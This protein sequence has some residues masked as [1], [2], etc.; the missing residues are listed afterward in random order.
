MILPAAGSPHS[1][2]SGTA[3]SLSRHRRPVPGSQLGLHMA[4]VTITLPELDLPS[5]HVVLAQAG[6]GTTAIRSI[7]GTLPQIDSCTVDVT[8]TDGAEHPEQFPVN[9]T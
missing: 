9:L 4:T 8:V 5:R 7:S 1:D 3:R 6:Q 2:G